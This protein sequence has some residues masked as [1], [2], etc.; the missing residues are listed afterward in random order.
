MSQFF[1]YLLEIVTGLVTFLRMD[2]IAS[3]TTMEIP[4]LWVTDEVEQLLLEAAEKTGKSHEEI[5]EFCLEHGIHKILEGLETGES[6]SEPQ[7]V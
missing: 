2:Q 6:N 3:V 4:P 5:L 7:N 1:F